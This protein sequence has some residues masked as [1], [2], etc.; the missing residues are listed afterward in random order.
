MSNKKLRIAISIWMFKPGTGG[1]Q[2]HA[3]MLCKELE[4]LGHEVILVTRAYSKVPKYLDYLYF[5]EPA[6]DV[7]VNGVKVRP[8]RYSR[9]CR[10]VQWIL[11][12]CIHRRGLSTFGLWLYRMQARKAFYDAFSGFDVIHHVGQAIA[13]I[14]FAASDVAKKLKTPYLVQ[15][16][17]HPYQA[18]DDPIDHRSFRLA[19]RLLVHTKYEKD[20][21]LS[22]G[23]TMPINVVGNGIQDRSDGNEVRFRA[24]YALK[25]EIILYLG[26]KNV[27][28]GYTLIREA[29]Q[30]LKKERPNVS[31]VAIG[32]PALNENKMNIIK[33]MLDLEFVS[34]QEK[35]DA[36]AACS[37]LCV[38]SE[39]ESFG[40]VYMEA[41]RYRKPVVARALPVLQELLEH[42]KAGLLLGHQNRNTQSVDLGSGELANGLLD[43]LDNSKM[44]NDL[45]NNCYRVSESFLWSKVASRF[46]DAYIE[47]IK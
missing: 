22:K 12:K 39:G 11:S 27:D 18:G 32:P 21:F 30:I 17:C 36:L 26:R 4:K 47:C 15:P 25:G 3:E 31:L 23:Y 38:P 34:E 40:L 24:K 37:C 5:N 16:T 2:A 46:V 10:P 42:G 41:G 35:H 13:L 1:L 44:M 43:L 19:D 14:P 28:K 20:Y 45:G 33:D 29:F 7:L 6:G 8:L 9:F